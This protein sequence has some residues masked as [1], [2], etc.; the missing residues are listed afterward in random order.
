LKLKKLLENHPDN[1]DYQ[2]IVYIKEIKAIQ[3]HLNHTKKKNSQP[4]KT[5]KKIF[6]FLIP[7]FDS[8]F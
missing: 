3:K 8:F 4:T 6:L 7:F 2:Q 5:K 1:D